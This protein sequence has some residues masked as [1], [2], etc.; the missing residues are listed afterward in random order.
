MQHIKKKV[1]H[2]ISHYHDNLTQS[3]YQQCTGVM[4]TPLLQG[5]VQYHKIKKDHN[6]NAVK[7]ELHALDDSF[8]PSFN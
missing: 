6:I 4:L 5:M 2:V 1:N 3:T 7:E 8:V